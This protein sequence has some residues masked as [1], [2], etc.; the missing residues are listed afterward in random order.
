[1]GT[2]TSNSEHEI[3]SEVQERSLDRDAKPEASGREVD[4]AALV[5]SAVNLLLYA[6][7]ESSTST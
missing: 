4:H 6:H 1:M 2:E 5:D 7:A 3:T